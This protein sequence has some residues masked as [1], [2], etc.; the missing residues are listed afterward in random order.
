MI[1]YID[2]IKWFGSASKLGNFQIQAETSMQFSH[3]YS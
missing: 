1:L 2:D 3:H